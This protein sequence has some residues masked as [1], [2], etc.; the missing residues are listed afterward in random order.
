MS[1]LSW[2]N[3]TVKLSDLLPWTGNPKTSTGKNAKQLQDS[4]DELGQFQTVAIEPTGKAGVY[5]VADGHQRLSA[6][7]AKYGKAAEID[8]RLASRPLTET[9]RR[10]IAIYSRQ[11]GAWD[12]DTLSG[13][14]PD[15]LT[16][17]GFDADLLGEWGRDYSNLALM[18]A[19][20]D[21]ENGGG[22]GD[23]D[24][25]GE[26]PLFA[27]IPDAIWPTDNKFGIPLLSIDRQAD[28][29]EI[30]VE[31]WGAKKR[32]TGCGTL[33]FY[34]EDYRFAALWS[35]PDDIMRA[36]AASFVEPNFSIYQDFPL[37]VALWRTYQKRWLARY[38]QSLGMRCFVDLN[39]N[40]NYYDV[41][42]LGVPKGWKAY[43]TRGYSDRLEYT[44]QEL[45]MAKEHAGTDDIMFVVY[46]G[47]KQVKAWCEDNGAVWI[48]EDMDRAKGLYEEAI[49]G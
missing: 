20:D 23:D 28:A 7:L 39:V 6:W 11:I 47:G 5:Q 8:A 30:P 22:D 44:G 36:G 41:N 31:I 9:E 12:W 26:A 42:L 1:D 33:A 49:Y 24:D 2:T 21:D 37:A 4:R 45:G 35:K 14:E 48:S 29:L 27:G 16:E 17:W 32:G 43:A 19:A 34:T 38:W 10:K 46:G 13:W 15:E 40:P 18:I 25:G 3:V